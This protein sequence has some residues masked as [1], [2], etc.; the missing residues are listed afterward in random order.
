[1]MNCQAQI[2]QL[3]INLA[4]VDMENRDMPIVVDLAT[5]YYQPR[6]PVDKRINQSIR[7]LIHRVIVK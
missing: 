3:Q 1:M 4:R 6:K 7:I 5:H 2:L